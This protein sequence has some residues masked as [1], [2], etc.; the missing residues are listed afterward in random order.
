[1]TTGD[2]YCTIHGLLKC[3]C[4]G[5]KEAYKLDVIHITKIIHYW[6]EDKEFQ[7]D[8]A[9]IELIRDDT[10][11]IIA[12]YGDSYHDNGREKAEGFIDG[13]EWATRKKVKLTTIQLADEPT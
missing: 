9:S 11:K 4:G 1:M 2:P 10:H 6:E 13:V 8:Y 12:T 3:E 5:Y 7:G